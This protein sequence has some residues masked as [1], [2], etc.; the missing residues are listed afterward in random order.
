MI[1]IKAAAR[2]LLLAL[3]LYV[4]DVSGFFAARYPTTADNVRPQQLRLDA[5]SEPSDSK[6][7][8]Y[9]KVRERRDRIARGE[10]ELEEGAIPSDDLAEVSW[11]AF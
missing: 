10:D 3:L 7:A 2:P 9:A 5:T 1:S 11:C 6:S 8:Y 4:G